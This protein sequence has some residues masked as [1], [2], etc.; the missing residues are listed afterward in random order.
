MR[1]GVP[2]DVTLA[3]ADSLARRYSLKFA[4]NVVGVCS[5]AVV[6]LL[7]PRALGPSVFGDFSF[8]TA[9][10]TRLVGFLNLGS[11]LAF[12]TRLSQRPGETGLV[13]FY[14]YVAAAVGV[15]TGLGIAVTYGVSANEYLWPG[16]RAA[17]VFAAAGWGLLVWYSDTTSQVCDAVGL[18]VSSEKMRMAQ[19]MSAAVLATALFASG[20]LSLPT[21]FAYQYAILIALIVAWWVLLRRH[22]MRVETWR[23]SRVE[24]RG[25]FREFA[26]YCHPLVVY[27]FAGFLVGVLDRWLLQR[28]A[29]SVEQ[30]FFG[31][32]YQVGAFCF[33][34]TSAMSPLI[35]REFSVAFGTRDLDRMA[36]VFRRYIP[37]LYAVAAWLAAFTA[38]EGDRVVL[39]FGG[40]QFAAAAGA[41]SI[42]ALY[43][44]HQTYGQ[45]SGSIFYATGQTTRYR[46]IGLVSMVIGVP[47]TIGL[48]AAARWWGFSQASAL[49]LK[50]VVLQFIAVN[51]QLWYNARFLGLSFWRYFGHQLAVLGSMLALAAGGRSLGD[52]VP[53]P[54]LLQFLA[55]GAVY[56]AAVLALVM[57]V[58]ATFGLQRADVSR[59]LTAVTGKLK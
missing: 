23:L 51:V 22:G 2:P 40:S 13:V 12:Y 8:L 39:F 35:M 36:H 43:P 49:A 33:L 42:M 37:S 59:L 3:P 4:A 14:S 57:A 53:G 5:S 1:T 41:V 25:Y 44:V 9:F 16:Q 15:V 7:V 28:Y 50:F 27:T 21:Y 38:V 6:Q 10:F 31:L 45:L 47:L 58:P 34:F 11:A 48:L 56:S 32:S 18:T 52:R 24:L 29:G 54:E 17:L 26:E 46:N 19:R 55:G 20:M 30:G